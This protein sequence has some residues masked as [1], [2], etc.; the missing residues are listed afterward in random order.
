MKLQTLDD[1]RQAIIV[2]ASTWAAEHN[3]TLLPGDA[4]ALADYAMVAIYVG[5]S[6]LEVS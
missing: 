2:A 6:G 3:R 1:V 4:E 5:T